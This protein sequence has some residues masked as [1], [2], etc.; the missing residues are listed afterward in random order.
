MMAQALAA[1]SGDVGTMLGIS[2]AVW[3]ALKRGCGLD[4]RFGGGSAKKA[5][6]TWVSK[7]LCSGCPAAAGRTEGAL[8]AGGAACV[9]PGSGLQP[10]LC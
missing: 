9:L 5:A 10:A 4:G 3:A 1:G 6:G 2:E 8:Q 7:V